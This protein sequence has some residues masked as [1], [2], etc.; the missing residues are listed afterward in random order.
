[1]QGNGVTLFHD[2]RPTS[3]LKLIE[4]KTFETDLMH[5]YYIVE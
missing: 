2:K 4:I 3:F 1:M 5:L